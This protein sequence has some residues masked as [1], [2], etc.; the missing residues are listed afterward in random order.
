MRPAPSH[1]TTISLHRVSVRVHRCSTIVV[2][3][4]FALLCAL[5][6]YSLALDDYGLST[7]DSFRRFL[8]DGRPR[9]DFLGVYLVQSM[10]LPRMLAAVA[11]DAALEIAGRIS[12][13]I[14][15][16][17]LGNLDIVGLSTGYVTDVLIAIIIMDSSPAVIGIGALLG[18]L[19]SGTFILVYTGGM[20]VTGIRV[21][22]VG[23]GCSA[24]LRVVNLLLIIR[25]P[26]GTAQRVQ[27]WSTGSLSGVTI[28]HLTPLLIMIAGV[29]AVCATCTA[30]LDLVVMGDSITTGLSVRVRQARI[31]LTVVAIL[32]VASA[33][34]VAGSVIFVALAAPHVAYRLCAAEGVGFAS[35]T[36]VDTLFVLISDVRVQGLVAPAELPVGTV[37]GV[38]EGLYLLRLLI[39]E[40]RSWLRSL[41]GRGLVFGTS[42]SAMRKTTWF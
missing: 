30:P 42:S 4:R 26:L 11:V 5:T 10:R 22:F 33:T 23:I 31:L 13:V 24:A 12:Q 14:S 36:I 19:A 40:V 8:G 15:G 7:A 17:P 28:A 37:T 18:G 3:I 32:F 1:Y 41:R 38:V 9:D 35:P 25:V 27:L 34:A 20:R 39:R 21:I 2:F 16:N 6:V 29:V